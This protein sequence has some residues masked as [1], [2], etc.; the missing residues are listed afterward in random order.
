[1]VVRAIQ[2]IESKHPIWFWNT[3][4]DKSVALL[5]D[6]EVCGFGIELKGIKDANNGN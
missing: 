5:Y 3:T 6:H 4:K 2:T 1:M